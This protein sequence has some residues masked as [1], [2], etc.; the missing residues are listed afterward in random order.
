ME[1]Q[2]KKA[3]GFIFVMS[4]LIGFAQSAQAQSTS[5]S[6]CYAYTDCYRTDP[7]GRSVYTG[8]IYCKVYGSSYV[9]GSGNTSS[10][11]SWY[12]VPYQSVKCSGFTQSTDRFGRRVWGWQDY[13]FSCQ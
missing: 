12:T 10:A 2:M 11:C 13:S 8:R 6:S 1:Y 3:I 9:Y 5:Y 4:A 7:W